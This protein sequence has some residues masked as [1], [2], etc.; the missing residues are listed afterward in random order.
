MI[1]GLPAGPATNPDIRSYGRRHGRKL[2]S[3]QESLLATVLPGISIVLATSAPLPL[4]SLFAAHIEDVW[5]E[6]GFGG[7]EHL[8]WQAEHHKEVGLIGCEPFLDGVVKAVSAIEERGLFNVRL[9]PDDARPLLRWLPDQSVGRVFI[10]FPDPWPK[11]RHAKRRLFSP[12]MLQLLAR[13]MRP[14]SELRVATDIA[15]YACAVLLAIRAE[16]AFAWLA[17]GP[18]DWR[19]RMADW[20]PTRYEQKAT[21]VGRRCYYF[22]FRRV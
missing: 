7:G 2:S 18:A 5:L 21:G 1:R 6:I 15:E 19:V 3:R 14:D 13:V 17:Q 10:L 16:P 12:E 8:L 20:P 9:H 22:T 11:K 4:T